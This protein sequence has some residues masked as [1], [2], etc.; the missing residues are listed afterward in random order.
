MT[1]KVYLVLLAASA[2]LFLLFPGLDLAVSGWFYRPGA[3][4]QLGY[5]PAFTVIR[6]GVPYMIAAAV[7]VAALLLVVN[8][9]RGTDVLQMRAR[10]FAFV[11]LAL[12]LGPGLL[13]NVVLKDHWGRARPAHV[14][15]FGGTMTFSPALLPVDACDHNCS[16]VAGDAAA[17]YFLLA[18]ALL[19]RRRRALAVAG[20]LAIG[21]GLGAV[22]VIQGGHFLSDVV[23]AGL[24]VGGLTWG[25][26]HLMMTPAGR[27]RVARLW[28]S[29]AGR[30]QLAALA[31]G[32]V[33]AL[34]MLAVDRPVATWVRGLDP[35]VHALSGRFSQLGLST[36][37][38][39]G[40]A[41]LA[42]G[43]LVAARF[44]DAPRARRWRSYALAPL[45]VFASVAL[46]GLTTDVVKALLGRMRPKL[47]L[48]D[49]GYGFDF[50]HTR[51]D[52]LSFPSGHAT[53]AFALATALALLWP[54]YTA[55]YVL[56]ALAVGASRVLA[57]AH[58]L[59]DVMAGALVGVAVTLYV[60]AVY[61]A[62]GVRVADT[63]AGR[64]AWRGAAGW[65]ARLALDSRTSAG[66]ASCLPIRRPLPLIPSKTDELPHGRG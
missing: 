58:F 15:E 6:E 43:G 37:W 24:F 22:R 30:L 2:A 34:S 50:L 27:A 53:T 62:N 66:T 64:A 21:S 12:L 63:V 57:N 36:G 40:A 3:G 28:A 61:A 23:F 9:V 56:F 65:A 25:L 33:V 51:A 7:A 42:A 10:G 29:G 55:A 59:S 14:V 4:W 52:Y 45:F 47:F 18:F 17:G 38:L 32:L 54:R 20:A 49:G 44:A 26:H 48:R 8:L 13:A 1:L 16:F 19:A 39:I 31:T 60:R 35:A 11:V 5:A 46:A 41:L